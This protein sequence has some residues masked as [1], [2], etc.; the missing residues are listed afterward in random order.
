MPKVD[1]DLACVLNNM[2]ECL[3]IV[4]L[5]CLCRQMPMLVYKEY[6]TEMSPR[7]KI[8]DHQ[9]TKETDK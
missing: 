1:R 3:A 4:P 7:A 8:A 6:L 5:A 2:Q 9:P